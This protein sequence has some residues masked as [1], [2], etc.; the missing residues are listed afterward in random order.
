MIF[1]NEDLT[2]T[3]KFKDNYGIFL[4]KYP[5]PTKELINSQFLWCGFMFN[6]IEDLSSDNLVLFKS[7]I[8]NEGFWIKL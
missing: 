2:F 5:V 7:D 8:S 6:Y 4:F 3:E 1:N